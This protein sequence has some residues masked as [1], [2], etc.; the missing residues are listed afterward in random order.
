MAARHLCSSGRP[1]QDATRACPRAQH[2]LSGTGPPARRPRWNAVGRKWSGQPRRPEA[3]DARRREPPEP[4]IVDVDPDLEPATGRGEELVGRGIG[5]GRLPALLHQQCLVGLDPVVGALT[6]GERV[7]AV[8]DGCVRAQCLEADGVVDLG[9]RVLQLVDRLRLL[10]GSR[11]GES[12]RWARSEI[13]PPA[14]GS[15]ERCRRG[16]RRPR[17]QSARLPPP[18]PLGAPRARR[19]RRRPG[20]P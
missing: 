19:A 8:V 11:T 18:E 6:T 16:C 4:G 7:L 1:S 5:G 2:R 15:P 10:G 20:R 13:A 12:H 3:L 9:Q 14:R 17:R